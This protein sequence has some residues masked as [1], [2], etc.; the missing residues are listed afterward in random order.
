MRELTLKILLIFLLIQKSKFKSKKLKPW[1]VAGFKCYAVV[2]TKLPKTIDFV[3]VFEC[4]GTYQI[5]HR[6]HQDLQDL[7]ISRI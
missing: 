7:W 6:L 1:Y 3:G 4:V 2:R 5:P